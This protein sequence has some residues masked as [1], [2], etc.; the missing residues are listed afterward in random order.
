MLERRVTRIDYNQHRKSSLSPCRVRKDSAGS[1]LS[2]G[3]QKM[4]EHDF[5]ALLFVAGAIATG[6]AIGWLLFQLIV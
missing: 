1:F 4:D 6:W 3:A 2:T 5:G